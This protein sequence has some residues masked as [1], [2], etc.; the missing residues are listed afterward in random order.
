ML[1]TGLVMILACF[2]Y[3]VIIIN[4]PPMIFPFANDHGERVTLD[5][6]FG[7]SWYLTLFTGIAVVVLSIV[8]LFMT[9]FFPRQIAV[10]FHHSVV[11]EDEFFQVR[12]YN[13]YDC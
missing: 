13:Y 1:T 7:W 6:H 8:I 4:D 2:C 9:Y 10:V 11:E 12:L 3:G 5:P